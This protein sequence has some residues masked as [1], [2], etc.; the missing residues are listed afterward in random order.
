MGTGLFG[1]AQAFM[2]QMRMMREATWDELVGIQQYWWILWCCFGD[3]NIVRFPSEHRGEIRLTLAM[4]KFSEFVD[5][6]NLV[7]LPLEG[8]S[9]TWSS[10]SDLI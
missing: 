10:G 1:L 6:L 2:A 4:E 8:G 7:D 5:D 3:F 9:Y